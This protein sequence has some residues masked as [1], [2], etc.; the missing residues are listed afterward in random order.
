[1]RNLELCLKISPRLLALI[2]AI[3]AT[4]SLT[5][6]ILITPLKAQTITNNKPSPTFT[7]INALGQKISL[8]SFK[9]KTVVLEWYNPGCPFVKKFYSQG[10][11]QRF[12]RQAREQ[13]AVWLTINSSA[14]G[15]QGHITQDEAPTTARE[16]GLDPSHLLLDHDGQVGRA[17]GAKTTPHIFVIDQRGN[18]AYS[19]AIDSTP[20]TAQSDI[21]NSD[22]Y[23]LSAIKALANGQA[24][25]P[26]YT[27]PYG[28]S[29]KY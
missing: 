20:S 28:C 9:G 8:D 11:M 19:G 5:S 23:V 17:F 14:P 4:L 13:G 1:M 6:S 10:D 7:L 2:L 18:L 27:A 26:N 22:N 21:S 3:L 16:N 29:V 15:R 25:N 12:Q 24:P